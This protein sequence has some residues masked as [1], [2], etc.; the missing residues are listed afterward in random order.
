MYTLI[1]MYFKL[2]FSFANS[3]SGTPT[4]NICDN[5]AERTFSRSVHV[6]YLPSEKTYDLCSCTIRGA[7]AMTINA[8]RAA[9][10][11]LYCP[12]TLC[13]NTR[14][15]NCSAY[16]GFSEDDR[17]ITEKLHSATATTVTLNINSRSNQP[18]LRMEFKGNI[19]YKSRIDYVFQYTGYFI[20]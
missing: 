9:N 3:L 8:Y 4:Q 19:K 16:N 17:K 18:I 14:K 2:Q 6:N 1:T 15:Y 11:A 10:L 13:V 12:S 20:I 5:T 7:D